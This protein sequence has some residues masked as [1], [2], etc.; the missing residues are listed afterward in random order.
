MAYQHVQS[1]T[2]EESRVRWTKSAISEY[3][4]LTTKKSVLDVGA[5]SSPFR[6]DCEQ[7]GLDYNS[8]DFNSYV[9]E[10]STSPGG[11]QNSSWEYA[12]HNYVCDILEIPATKKF[13]MVICTEV[14]EHIPDPVRALEK[15]V[16]LLDE[17]GIIL[18][19]VPLVSF[20]HQAPFWYQSGLSPFWFEYWSKEFNLEILELRVFGDY[21]DFL[22]QEISRVL[23]ILVPVKGI[24][25]LLNLLRRFTSNLRKPNQSDLLSCAGFGTLY[26]AKRITA[27]S[28]SD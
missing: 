23:P 27:S 14:L 3:S 21:V 5:G 11:I 8:H 20:M 9:P 1:A 22:N 7:A 25:L 10:K 17:D 18:I 28:K 13:G 6:S 12:E 16:N 24:G 15:M 26:V 4:A 19:T 2:N